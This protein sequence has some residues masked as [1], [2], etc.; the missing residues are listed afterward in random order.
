LILVKAGAGESLHAG[1]MQRMFRLLSGLMMAFALALTGPGTVGAGMVM[2]G[3]MAVEICGT[4][5]IQVLWLDAQ[6]NPADPASHCADC[7]V[8]TAQGAAAL[9]A[10]PMT[11]AFRAMH[12]RRL[13]RRDPHC[14]APARKRHTRPEARGPPVSALKKTGISGTCC[15]MIGFASLEFG[16]VIRTRS[17]TDRGHPTKDACR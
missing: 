15:P 7:P 10:S 8:C 17:M 9:P 2:P 12:A 16:Q 14:P 5:A 13:S 11:A 4:D 6:G 1:I 3:L